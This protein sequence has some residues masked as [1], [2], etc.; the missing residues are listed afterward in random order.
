M[1]LYTRDSDEH[2]PAVA[3]EVFDVSGAG[4][5]GDR[6]AR[7]ADR[8]RRAAAGGRAHREPGGRRRRR[9]ARHRGRDAGRARLTAPRA[10]S[11]PRAKTVYSCTECGGQSPKWQ[12]QCPHCGVVEHARRDDRDARAGALPE[13]R[14]QDEHRA[15]PRE[16]RRRGDPA[17]SDRRRGVRSRAGRRAR[18]RAA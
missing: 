18:V 2:I 9:Q 6:D 4:R 15:P 10:S 14:R 7:R 12:G 11:W 17:L 1:S 3:R 5:H 8:R 13:R 16:R